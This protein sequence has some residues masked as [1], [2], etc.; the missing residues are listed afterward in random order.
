MK[1]IPLTRGKFA[2]VDDDDYEY[3]S[4]WK[5]AT[6]T[7]GYAIRNRPRNGQPKKTQMYM[8][9]VL[10]GE[11]QGVQVDHANCDRLDNRRDNLRLATNAQNQQNRTMQKN[12]TTGFKGVY[13][14][15]KLPYMYEARIGVGGKNIY[16]GLFRSP[17]EASRAYSEASK[18]HHR[19]F[20]HA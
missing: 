15:S 6:S 12:N 17:E 3:L 19:E 10:L 20:S 7:S 5:W 18:R 4:R 1:K 13:R 2:L 14:N 11:P 16:L 8:H 9:R